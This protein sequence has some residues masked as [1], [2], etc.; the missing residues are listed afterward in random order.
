MEEE[1]RGEKKTNRHNS[2]TGGQ[3]R[4]QRNAVGGRRREVKRFWIVQF[5]SWKSRSDVLPQMKRRR[6]FVRLSSGRPRRA[7]ITCQKAGG[8]GW[9]RERR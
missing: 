6:T 7:R 3:N 4:W 9:G 1:E 5:T 8:E 2:K